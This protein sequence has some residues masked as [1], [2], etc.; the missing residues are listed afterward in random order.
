MIIPFYNKQGNLIN[1]D[2]D[3]DKTISSQA[4]LED[5]NIVLKI[6]RQ[7]LEIKIEELRDRINKT[8]SSEQEVWNNIDKIYHELHEQRAL[9]MDI[10]R[11]LE[12]LG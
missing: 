10:K 5:E 3:F 1:M 7:N 12:E 4:S 6:E 8:K 11:K 2:I 9:L